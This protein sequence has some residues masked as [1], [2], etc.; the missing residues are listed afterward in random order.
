M[1]VHTSQYTGHIQKTC[2]ITLCLGP[3]PWR[4]GLS[5]HLEQVSPCYLPG[6]PS[7]SRPP[8]PGFTCVLEFEPKSSCF[9]SKGCFH[10]EPSP[11]RCLCFFLQCWTPS[12]LGAPLFV[13]PTPL[14]T[15]LQLS[16]QHWQC[17]A[18][19]C[20]SPAWPACPCASPSAPAGRSSCGGRLGTRGHLALWAECGCGQG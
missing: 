7:H 11:Q 3:P 2:S 19:R 8:Y 5:L 9:K 18:A 16:V 10:T 14:L 20:C 6:S 1:S 13:C 17:G 4:C 12:T 15:C